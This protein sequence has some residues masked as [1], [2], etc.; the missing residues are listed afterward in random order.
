MHRVGGSKIVTRR[1][2]PVAVHSGRGA[3]IEQTAA[4]RPE[5]KELV[6]MPLCGQSL[7]SAATAY[8]LPLRHSFDAYFRRIMGRK[9]QPCENVR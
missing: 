7:R 4:V 8:D 9:E 3:L 5:L 1:A 6:F 2:S